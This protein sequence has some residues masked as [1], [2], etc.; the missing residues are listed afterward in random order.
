MGVDV[1]SFGNAFP[2]PEDSIALAQTDAF[3]GLYKKLF[4][5]KDG[6]KLLGGI[7]VGDA[8]DYPKLLSLS[9]SALPLSVKPREL[10]YGSTGGGEEEEMADSFQVCQCNNVSK[11]DVVAAIEAKGGD[12]SLGELKTCSKAGTGCGGCV[13]LVEQILTSEK[14]KAGVSTKKVVCAHLPFTRQELVHIVRTE[15]HTGYESVLAKHG[16]APGSCEICKPAVASILASYQNDMILDGPLLA[17]QDSND[18]F[19]ANIQRGGSYSVVPRVP[20]GEITPAQ[21]I[22]LGEVAQR[23]NLYAKITGGQRVDLFG[24]HRADLPDIWSELL[25]VGFE[26]GHAYGK[27]LRTVKSCVGS[28]WCR[29]GMQDSVDFAIKVENR[30]KGIRAPHKVKSAVSGCVRECAEAQSK[31]FGFIATETGYTVFVGGNGGIT[32]VHAQILET[33]CSE[34]RA[35]QLIDRFFM[36][37]IRTADRLQRTAPWLQELPG[38]LEYL[39]EVIVEDKLGICDSLEKEMQFLVDTYKDEWREVVESPERRAQFADFVNAPDAKEDGIEF[40]AVRGQKRPADWPKAKCPPT[41]IPAALDSGLDLTTN[42]RWV[43]VG[44]AADFPGDAGLTVLYGKSQLAVFNLASRGEWFATQNMCP[45]KRAFVLSRSLVGEAGADMRPYAA[46]PLHKKHFD[47]ASGACT[48][49]AEEEGILT[50]PVDITDGGD[51]MLL[52]PPEEILDALLATEKH[53][54]TSCSKREFAAAS[55]DA[56]FTEGE[57]KPDEKPLAGA[58]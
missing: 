51:V 45:H 57:T 23:W 34:E 8:S 13:Q 1:A 11:G 30:Y 14:K 3:E 41:G 22:R 19:L 28:T 2:D 26:S 29:F 54:I 56:R 17:L 38:G 36:F 58:V 37:Y 10:V 4:F 46:C 39:K 6:T 24:A 5:S 12:I 47:L 53:Q 20:G 7:L 31:D 18:R 49:D 16:G 15:R 44:A 9:K 43:R 33:D 35:I 32:P 25:E 52:L 55:L 40:V 27:A 48:T 21:L 42:A 50:F